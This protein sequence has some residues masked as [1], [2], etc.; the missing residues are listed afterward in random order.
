[1]AQ[2]MALKADGTVIGWGYNGYGLLNIPDGLT[3]VVAI[4]AGFDHNLALKSDGTLSFGVLT[5]GVSSASRKAC[6]C[7]RH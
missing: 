4:A 1:M 2:S 5:I 7:C 3:G 6:Q